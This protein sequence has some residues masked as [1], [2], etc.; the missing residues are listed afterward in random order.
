MVVPQERE[1]AA[2]DLSLFKIQFYNFEDLQ[3]RL[4][5]KNYLL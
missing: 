4:K 5:R 3:K 1:A 2:R